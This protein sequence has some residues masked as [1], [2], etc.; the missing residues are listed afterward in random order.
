VPPEGYGEVRRLARRLGAEVGA[1]RKVTDLGHLPRSRQIGI[2]GR[3]VAPRLY[4]ALGVGG[5]SN[6][7]AGVRRAATVVAVNVDPSA[8][9]LA[10]CDVGIVGDWREVV[11]A[12][13]WRLGDGGPPTGTTRPAE[14]V[15]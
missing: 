13:L 1:T 14:A 11:A 9:A 10:G 3:N 5:S 4:L 7:L 2:T 8:P 12:L 6:H 15:A